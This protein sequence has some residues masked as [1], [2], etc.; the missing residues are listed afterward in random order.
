MSIRQRQ[1]G[2]KSMSPYVFLTLNPRAPFNGRISLRKVND[3]SCQLAF[4]SLNPSVFEIRRSQGPYVASCP[5]PNC[6]LNHSTAGWSSQVSRISLVISRYP[7]IMDIHALN[8]CPQLMLFSF[9]SSNAAFTKLSINA[10]PPIQADRVCYFC[11]FVVL[12]C[13]RRQ[14]LKRDIVCKKNLGSKTNLL[15]SFSLEK[16]E[17]GFL[18]GT[19]VGRFDPEPF[20]A[21]IVFFYLFFFSTPLR[22][23]WK[24]VLSS[25]WQ[26]Q[27][28]GFIAVWLLWYMYKLDTKK[29]RLWV[30]T[31]FRNFAVW[32][33]SSSRTKQKLKKCGESVRS[34]KGGSA[35]GVRWTK[36]QGQENS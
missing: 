28:G 35:G 17:S 32:F 8:N 3:L 9:W 15:S 36:P 31:N 2:S 24:G 34:Q 13:G 19:F 14:A 33:D 30:S 22:N 1:L 7:T 21:P 11:I 10:P 6:T 4:P 26:L 18:V 5:R 23:F 20:V 25:P 12:V 16:E 27:R 29:K